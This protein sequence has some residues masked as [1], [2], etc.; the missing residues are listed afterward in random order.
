[1]ARRIEDW[2]PCDSY[3]EPIT[4]TAAAGSA[5]GPLTGFLLVRHGM[6]SDPGVAPLNEP[7]VAVVEPTYEISVDRVVGQMDALRGDVIEDPVVLAARIVKVVFDEDDN[8]F[9]SWEDSLFDGDDANSPFLWQ[10]YYYLDSGGASIMAP[11]F[12]QD[13]DWSFLD[14]RVGRMLERQEALMCLLQIRP[15]ANTP[16]ATSVLVRPYLRSF[17]KMMR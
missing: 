16:G 8:S 9:A 6:S 1:M 15:Q 14:V 5:E 2:V 3:S 13:M 11:F 7:Q 17:C 12:G 10:R 4:V